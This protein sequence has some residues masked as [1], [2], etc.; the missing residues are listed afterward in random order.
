MGFQQMERRHSQ[1]RQLRD[2]RRPKTIWLKLAP[3]LLHVHTIAVLTC[4]VLALMG[5]RW[6]LHVLRTEALPGWA[7][8]R[9]PTATPR[10]A[11]NHV[12]ERFTD[13]TLEPHDRY[14]AL[15]DYFFNG[16]QIFISGDGARI[17]FPGFPGELGAMHDGFRG[18][19]RSAPLLAAMVAISRDSNGRAVAVLRHGFI[20]G[21]DPASPSY[22]GPIT[23]DNDM[24]EDAADIARAVF[25]SKP[26]IWD[27]LDPV[28]KTQMAAWLAPLAI[29]QKLGPRD[30]LPAITVE[31][32]LAALNMPSDIDYSRAHLAEA[33][34]LL[35]D[36]GWFVASGSSPDLSNSWRESY[37]LAWIFRIDPNFAP[38]FTR[39]VLADSADL[40][41]HLITPKG[42][43]IFGDTLCARTAMM[44][45]VIGA[46]MTG[47]RIGADQ[48]RAASDAIWHYFLQENG[49]RDGAIAQGYFGPD[50]VL[51]ANS[52]GPGTC[53]WGLRGL[54][55]TILLGQDDPFWHV[56]PAKL[57]VQQD[58]FHINLKDL[59][60]V[61]R[62]DKARETVS[63]EITANTRDTIPLN[64]YS[65]WQRLQT[66]LRHIPARPDNV[67]ARWSR[68]FYY[69]DKPLGTE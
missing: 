23:L 16:A 8:Y 3:L 21:T 46:Y 10:Y 43:P 60:W 53:Q 25:I 14:A 19:A 28:A 39:S 57:P 1:R 13:S 27:R 54:I 55:L 15:F 22:W 67:D 31:R 68:Q 34:A 38:D 5:A 47:S 4:L 40:T 18:F 65:E 17:L 42:V 35:T 64:P 69:A 11:D 7:Q 50:P 63:I 56:A 49:V 51:T 37:A 20:A 2:R 36:H 33:R 61:L 29:G 62:G 45:P 12:Y 52:E 32:V 30:L 48:A 44:A 6:S 66:R 41:L 26:Y 59:G 24:A 58:D 9:P